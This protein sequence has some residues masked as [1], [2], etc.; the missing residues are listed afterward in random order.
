MAA[1]YRVASCSAFHHTSTHD[2]PLS[3]PINLPV[4]AVAD[5]VSHHL[6]ERMTPSEEVEYA[7]KKGY[8]KLLE[9]RNMAQ[10]EK[11]RDLVREVKRT[12]TLTLTLTLQLHLQLH[13]ILIDR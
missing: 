3:P 4:D 2:P 8:P 13:L 6:Q 11:A 1:M 12:L 7:V 9:D 10:S 5:G